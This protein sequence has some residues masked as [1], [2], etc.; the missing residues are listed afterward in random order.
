MKYHHTVDKEGEEELKWEREIEYGVKF[1]VKFELI[2]IK[3]VH[4][5]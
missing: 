3:K 5:K 4:K 1:H 2:E